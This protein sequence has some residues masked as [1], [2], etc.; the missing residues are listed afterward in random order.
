MES[1]IATPE[2]C[3]SFARVAAISR[4]RAA[5]RAPEHDVSPGAP[6]DERKRGAEGTGAGDGDA[7]RIPSCAGA[8]FA[9]AEERR[10]VLVERPAR[11]GGKVGIG[12]DAGREPLRT[13]PGDHRRV[14]R[15]EIWRRRDEAR[16]GLQ[17]KAA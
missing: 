16:A 12:C 8:A 13:G 3:A 2:R 9:A 10:N 5:S 11:T 1:G 4:I 15:A 17:R 7:L 14:V 6:G